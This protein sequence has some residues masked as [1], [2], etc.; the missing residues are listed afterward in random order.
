MKTLVAYYS[1]KGY[2]EEIAL[3]KAKEE[4]ADILCLETITNT[5]GID[6]FRNCM[7]KCASNGK[8]ELFPYDNDIAAYDKIVICS[9]VWC[10]K[11]SLPMKEFITKEKHNINN[12][13]YIFVGF[14]SGNFAC[15]ADEAD[16]ILRLKRNK[17]TA[18]QC[19]WGKIK[20]EE[21]F[22]ND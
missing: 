12:A 20:K 10:G 3:K 17:Y 15:V 11:L 13:E 1:R 2:V 5:S 18:I 16:K 21:V 7:I 14:S 4:N 8:T 19:V 6:G 9:P 22:L